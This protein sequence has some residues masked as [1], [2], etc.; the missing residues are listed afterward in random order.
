MQPEDRGGVAESAERAACT[1]KDFE[2]LFRIVDPQGMTRYVHGFGHP[3]FNASGKPGEFVGILMD[4]TERRLAEALRDGESRILE[5]LARDAPL[6]EILEQLV[7]VVEAQFAS[8]LCSVLLLDEDGQHVR[9]GAAPSLPEAYTKAIDGLPIGPKA[10]S[11]GTAMYRREPVVVTDILQDPLWEPYRTVVEP[12]GLRACWST[13]ILAHS[14]KVLGSFAMY[15][16]EPRSPSQA[17]TRALEIATHLAGIAIERKLTHE[18]LQRS[19]AYLAEAQRLSHTGSWAEAPG[20]GEIRYWSEECYRVL[21]FDPHG[22]QPR[23]ERFFQRIY[24]DDQAKQRAT[25]ETALGMKADFEQD[26]RIVHPGGEIRDIHGV[27]HPVLSP[28][29]DLVL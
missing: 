19:E 23:F 1:G 12:Y 28:S 5:M 6:T 18:Q 24:P 11:C 17:E 3:V 10:G 13:P 9:H 14:G 16:R 25:A 20:T 27:G 4:V 22:G 8:L 15:Y 26:Y 2:A 21:G 7:R 29:G